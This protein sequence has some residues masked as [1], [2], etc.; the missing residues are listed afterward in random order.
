MP[1]LTS[2]NDAASLLGIAPA[3]LRAWAPIY[4]EFLSEFAR[5][6]RRQYTRR[7][8]AILQAVKSM[9]DDRLTHEQVAARLR[10]MDF[11]EEDTAPSAQAAPEPPGSARD[12]NS[13]SAQA[14]QTAST[15]LLV[16]SGQVVGVQQDQA[17]RL[18]ALE[19]QVADLRVTVARMEAQADQLHRLQD[20]VDDLARQVQSIG[21]HMHDHSIKIGYRK[22]E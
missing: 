19:T 3:T 13:A 10:T 6:G 2:P 11:G 17:Q 1:A 7:D 4:D 8:L 18:A 5:R 9:L 20:Q 22:V 12:A 21:S 14:E 15:A 16:L